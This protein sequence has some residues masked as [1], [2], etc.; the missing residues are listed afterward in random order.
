MLDDTMTDAYT[1]QIVP[2]FVEKLVQ[3]VPGFVQMLNDAMIIVITVQIIPGFVEMLGDAMFNYA[4]HHTIRL[5]A[6]Q[7]LTQVDHSNLCD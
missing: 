1:E 7:V 4:I 3:I 2:G 6:N 5:H